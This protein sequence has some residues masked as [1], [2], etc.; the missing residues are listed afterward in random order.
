MIYT[1]K[2]CIKMKAL[3]KTSKKNLEKQLKKGKRITLCDK[4]RLGRIK[5]E[6]ETLCMYF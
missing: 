3:T 2:G 1:M 4:K 6:G 5:K